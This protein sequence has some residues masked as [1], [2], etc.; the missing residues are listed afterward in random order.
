[1]KKVLLISL[2]TGVATSF[3]CCYAN[4]INFKTNQ[5][6]QK[7]NAGYSDMDKVI[8]I[9]NN[10]NYSTQHKIVT[11]HR[12]LK[13]IGCENV[14]IDFQTAERI[15]SLA[16]KNNINPQT[17][18]YVFTP[19]GCIYNYETRNILELMSKAHKMTDDEIK[20]IFSYS[21]KEDSLPTTTSAQEYDIFNIYCEEIVANG[22]NLNY[23]KLRKEYEKKV[24]NP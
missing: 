16:T 24:I 20:F 5:M 8:K 22:K 17:L 12:F 23:A 9:L 14:H 2:L 21:Y 18:K 11:L 3:L 10:D 13:E 6:I 19:K 7:Q 1:M 15:L 4:I